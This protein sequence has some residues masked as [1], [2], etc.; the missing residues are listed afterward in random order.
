TAELRLPRSALPAQPGTTETVAA[1]WTPRVTGAADEVV[2]L[3]GDQW[4]AGTSAQ[5]LRPPLTHRRTTAPPETGQRP[6]R[7]NG[8]SW[9]AGSPA[10]RSQ[11]HD[12]QAAASEIGQQHLDDVFLFDA[13]CVSRNMVP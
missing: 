7:F 6:D 4:C 9:E 13:K 11:P 2:P 12:L 5:T 1:T 8:R 3:D 10:I